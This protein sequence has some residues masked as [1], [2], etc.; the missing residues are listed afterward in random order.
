MKR[1]AYLIGLLLAPI[2]TPVTLAEWQNIQ[3]FPCGGTKL[4]DIWGCGTQVF[5]CGQDTFLYFDGRDYHRYTPD[6][7]ANLYSI[8]GSSPNNV[9]AV[10]AYGV[11]YH[12]NGKEL[13]RI[14]LGVN[15]HLQKV[16]GLPDGQV[17][18]LTS[19]QTMM[20]W[21]RTKWSVMT[22]PEDKDV[23]LNDIW[24]SF[25]RDIFAAGFKY[26]SDHAV[27]Y[28][29]DGTAWSNV[30]EYG[31]DDGSFF[32][33]WGS[34]PDDVYAA[35][36]IH[37]GYPYNGTYY[38]QHIVLHWDGSEW[39]SMKE[40]PQGHCKQIWGTSKNNIYFLTDAGLFHYDGIA[41]ETK[42]LP[43]TTLNKIWGT[44]PG[45]LYGVGPFSQIF[46]WDGFFWA[47]KYR[48]RPLNFTCVAAAGPDDLFVGGLC[49]SILHK[50]RNGW[51]VTS[52]DLSLDIVALQAFAPDDVYGVGN[53]LVH[54]DGHEWNRL[55]S[56][57]SKRFTAIWGTDGNHLLM[58]G[59]DGCY[60]WDGHTL[61][62]LDFPRQSSMR[63][64]WAKSWNDVFLA[65]GST[66]YHFSGEQGTADSYELNGLSID[67]IWGKSPRDVYILAHDDYGPSKLFHF[68]GETVTPWKWNQA[69]YGIE[70]VHQVRELS[71]GSLF[72]A[73]NLDVF[74]K[75]DQELL[76]TMPVSPRTQSNQWID[77]AN[78]ECYAVGY[79]NKIWKWNGLKPGSH[80][81]LQHVWSRYDLFDLFFKLNLNIEN[82]GPDTWE[83]V[84]IFAIMEIMGNY[85]S[86][87]EWNRIDQSD[88]LALQSMDAPPGITQVNIFDDLE[89]PHDPRFYV[90]DICFYGGVMDSNMHLI[91]DVAV[92][93]W[94]Y[95]N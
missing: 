64:I 30:L 3:P 20:H 63:C 89:K 37:G 2:L 60:F 74:L 54:W 85:Y 45:D 95:W 26:C 56:G 5:A 15:A 69:F 38:T 75:S 6:K 47:T 40:V 79:G 25:D 71:D 39:E 48:E 53:R 49:G 67:D 84:S 41:W 70:R 90:K 28:H 29:W 61:K 36:E 52:D 1:I 59:Y 78:G 57:G 21:D 17:F 34:G 11:A 51:H 68:D 7:A 86:W 50:D 93:E 14:D 32:S 72:L 83:D 58:A 8:W 23:H 44:A 18:V 82:P 94:Q 33:I 73:S 91:G 55:D 81:S 43:W 12:W 35:G 19:I 66:F 65:G 46:H 80:F 88:G 62:L 24:G 87:P 27:I 76:S 42:D 77:L 92:L 22:Y 10:G 9:Y 31:Y 4:N 13:K 16:W